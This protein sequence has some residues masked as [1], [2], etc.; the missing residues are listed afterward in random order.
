MQAVRG[1]RKPKVAFDIPGRVAERAA[2][3]VTVNDD[4]CWISNYSVASHGYAQIGW[5]DDGYRQI[6]T[7][8][9]ASWVH[10]H[11]Q[12][13]EGMTIDHTCRVRRCVNPSHL[14]MLSNLDNARDNGQEH[15]GTP[16]E[17]GD[18]CASGHAVLLY[19][20]GARHC[21]ECASEWARLKKFR[22]SLRLAEA[23]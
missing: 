23:A 14:R 22:Q 18:Q 2:T 11:G 5:Q 21:R 9:R 13:P 6:V 17:T 7:A 20:T 3:R 4:G 15:R 12:I 16:V 19:P 1:Y 8:H 10:V